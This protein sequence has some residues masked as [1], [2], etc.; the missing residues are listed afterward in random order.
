MSAKI[1]L[2]SDTHYGHAN[3]IKYCSRPFSTVKEMD[4]FMIAR[5]NEVVSDED[6]VYHL[7]DFALCDDWRKTQILTQLKG[8][9]ILVL[10]NH[11]L[12]PKELYKNNPDAIELAKYAYKAIG[13]DE[14]YGEGEVV[15]EGWTLVHRPETAKGK[16]LCGHIHDQWAVQDNRPWGSLN[17]NVGV[18][19]MDFKPVELKELLKQV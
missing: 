16:Y 12:W 9:K 8:S 7:G 6:T 18:D 1:F 3:I 4:D 19:V 15:L 5:W 11:D 10:G 13:F 14:V 17:I 2:T